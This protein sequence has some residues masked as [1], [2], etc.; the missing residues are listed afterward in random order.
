MKRILIG[1]GLMI[2]FCPN[3]FHAQSAKPGPEQSKL[4]GFLG[5]W[6]MD[7]EIKPGNSYGVPAGKFSQVER[8]EWMPGGFFLQM[9]REGKGAQGEFKHI[10]IYSYDPVLKK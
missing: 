2:G 5:V 4:A 3:L 1:V 9:N 10:W 6:S 8:Y 7:G